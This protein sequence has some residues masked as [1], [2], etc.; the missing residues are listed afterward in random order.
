VSEL[1]ASV[2]ICCYTEERL[3]DIY[4]AVESV[5]AQT[6]KPH[7]V[8]LAVDHNKHL[9]ERLAE[10][11]QDS[12]EVRKNSINLN[13]SP[14]PILLVLNEGAQ[15]LSETRNVGIRAAS[16]DIVVF[17]DDD[18]VAEPDWLENLVSPFHTPQS[19]Q[20]TV[21]AVGGRAIPLWP[22]GKRPFWFPEELDWI[23]GCTY[24]G[25]PVK[26]FNVQCATLNT[27]PRTSNIEPRTLNIEL[28]PIR[29]VHGCNMAFTKG[30]FE[31]AGLFRSETGRVGTTTGC[32][33]EADLCLRISHAMPKAL[34]VYQEQATIRHKVAPRR[35]TWRYLWQ[36]SYNEGLYKAKVQKLHHPAKKSTVN[37][38]QSTVKTSS[39]E[40]RKLNI[41]HRT[42]NVEHKTLST[43]S[44]Y[45]RYLVFKSI[46]ERLARF[47]H[48]EGLPQAA[49]IIVCIAA[50]GVGYLVGRIRG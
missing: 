26:K 1:T 47:Y 33:E 48:G 40:H 10:T 6:L 50:T 31:K 5:L 21:V 9:Y 34:I 35:T 45:L 14:V 39:S 38:P 49:A 44:S 30:G 42:L 36:R 29:N 46:P 2:I 8:I 41:E 18:A 13:Q 32:G 19:T 11:Y 12:I 24:K 37:S 43:E 27:E 17:V 22:N 4:E 15:G 25:L 20:E 28:R 7:E 23:V 16:G 3:K